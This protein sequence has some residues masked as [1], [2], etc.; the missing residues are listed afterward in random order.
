MHLPATGHPGPAPASAQT[1]SQFHQQ[2]AGVLRQMPRPVPG[3]QLQGATRNRTAQQARSAAEPE[4]ALFNAIANTERSGTGDDERMPDDLARELQQR[5]SRSDDRSDPDA[6]AE[7]QRQEAS[8]T[9][10]DDAALGQLRER[11]GGGAEIGGA[12][13]LDDALALAGRMAA[14]G[15]GSLTERMAQLRRSAGQDQVVRRQDADGVQVWMAQ[16]QA[17]SLHL[18]ASCLEQGAVLHAQLHGNGL[19]APGGSEHGPSPAERTG[20]GLLEAG[21]AANGG[22]LAT[23]IGARAGQGRD[24]RSASQLLAA[25]LRALP[26]AVWS[27][28]EARSKLLHDLDLTAGES[29]A[30]AGA[31]VRTERQLRASQEHRHA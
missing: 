31:A 26:D 16:R 2:R 18:L 8:H 23:R 25:A 13:A 17:A 15:E 28:K 5:A 1:H 4:Q 19:L 29:A 27:T 9:R 30:P 11:L 3:Q 6:V 22:A 14:H 7:L 24:G 12:S 10:P 20:L 21:R